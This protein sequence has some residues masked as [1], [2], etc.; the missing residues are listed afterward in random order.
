MAALTLPAVFDRIDR[1]LSVAP[2]VIED[3]FIEANPGLTADMMVTSCRRDTLVEL[4]LCLTRELQPRPCD[5][6]VRSCARRSA[7]LLPLR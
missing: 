1:D 4:R 6:E 3:A 7:R 5:A 2:Q